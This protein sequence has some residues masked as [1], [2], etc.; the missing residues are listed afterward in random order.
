MQGTSPPRRAGRLGVLALL[1]I[2]GHAFFVVVVT[3]LPFF[4][5]GY[6][7]A[8]DAISGLLLGPY[9][10]VLSGAFFAAGIGSLALAVGIYRTTRGV[11]GALS[12]CVLIGLWALGVA[13]AGVV[14][15]DAQG[16]PT[17]SATI[18]HLTGAGLAFFSAP[19]GILVLSRVFARDA[20]WSSFYPL[21]LAL[22]FA[23]VVALIDM[24]T[25]LIGLSNLVETLGPGAR[26][27]VEGVGIIQRVF[28]V[29][30]ILWMALAATR[31]RSIAKDKADRFLTLGR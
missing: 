3:L 1:G 22:G 5:P 31:L 28:V 6:S 19:A 30:V 27:S 10:F 26:R 15:V 25:I 13:L 29:T 14:L 2:F 16:N 12:G 7:S 24:T 9:G 17:E 4:N 21:S 23:A 8:D 18:L 11:R 20:Q